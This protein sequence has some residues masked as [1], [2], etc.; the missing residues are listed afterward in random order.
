MSQ[1][2]TGLNAGKRLGNLAEGLGMEVIQPLSPG[3]RS[4]QN[5]SGNG[6]DAIGGTIDT[7]NKT[8]PA[9]EMKGTDTGNRQSVGTLDQR[10][11]NWINEAAEGGL[12]RQ[13]LSS[14][15][16]AYAQYLRGLLR[17][18]Y[19]IRPYVVEIAVPAQGQTAIPTVVVTPWPRPT[20]MPRPKTAPYVPPKK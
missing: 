1:I 8:I 20:P 5:R 16:I 2:N 9:F 15:D 19:T 12:N 18:G 6:I 7:V 11:L 3:A 13:S 10:M 17:Q 14:A 4:I